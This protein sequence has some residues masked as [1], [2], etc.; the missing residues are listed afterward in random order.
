MSDKVNE[1]KEIVNTTTNSNERK[2][3]MNKLGIKEIELKKDD[4]L[5]F[6]GQCHCSGNSISP[7]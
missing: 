6:F 2:D 7:F 4:G 1:L 3:A 5:V